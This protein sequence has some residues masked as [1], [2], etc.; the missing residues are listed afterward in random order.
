MFCRRSTDRRTGSRGFVLLEALVAVAVAALLM[1]LLL[2]SFSQTWSS[3]RLVRE[4][5]E[6]MLVGRSL[7]T[8]RGAREKLAIGR[9]SGNMG[10]YAWTLHI[11][12]LPTPPAQSPAAQTRQ[13][14]PDQAPDGNVQAAQSGQTNQSGQAGQE[15][16]PRDWKL[17]DLKLEL[18]TP[19]GRRLNLET[20]RL[21]ASLVQ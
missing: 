13:A 2:Q 6:A 16:A 8:D 11:V 10:G 20:F 12:Q 14:G 5:A 9:D 19:T 1:G 15:P 7:M 3:V 21:G 18:V 4:D 17:Y